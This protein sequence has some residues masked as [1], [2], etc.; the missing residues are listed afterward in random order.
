M[1]EKQKGDE[2]HK[3]KL[4]EVKMNNAKKEISRKHNILDSLRKAVTSG[5]EMEKLY[6]RKQIYIENE[7][8][9]LEKFKDSF[10]IIKNERRITK[11][12]KQKQLHYATKKVVSAKPQPQAV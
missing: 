5:T 11:C 10:Y 7:V 1:L 8:H 6:V 4:L 12:K 2:I 3:N 9:N